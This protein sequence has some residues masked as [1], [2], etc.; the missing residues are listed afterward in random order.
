MAEFFI[1][2]IGGEDR[3][4]Y[5]CYIHRA[6]CKNIARGEYNV[7]HLHT[8]TL[9]SAVDWYLDDEL[10]NMGFDQEIVKVFSC[11]KTIGA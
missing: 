9:E 11:A 3:N 4:G 1:G 5:S 10:K 2:Y 6:G 7:T 8:G